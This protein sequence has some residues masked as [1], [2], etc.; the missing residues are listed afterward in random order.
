M[1]MRIARGSHADSL[2]WRN[3]RVAGLRS[4]VWRET[5]S[6]WETRVNGCAKE[7]GREGEREKRGE[8]GGREEVREDGDGDATAVAGGRAASECPAKIAG[9][10]GEVG[11]WVDG[12]SG[13]WKWDT[14]RGMHVQR[15]NKSPTFVF[16]FTERGT[17]DP[18]PCH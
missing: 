2:S 9:R 5:I 14:G 7:G 1:D 8:E 12:R 6:E 18:M 17:L 16:S 3:T 4:I 13:G 10:E 15:Q 11:H